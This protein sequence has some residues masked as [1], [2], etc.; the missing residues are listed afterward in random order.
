M[1][2]MHVGVTWDPSCRANVNTRVIREGANKKREKRK[3]NYLFA[4]KI[5]AGAEGRGGG[6]EKSGVKCVAGTSFR[7]YHRA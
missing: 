4:T 3:K 6:A 7:A 5:S 2:Q 1:K